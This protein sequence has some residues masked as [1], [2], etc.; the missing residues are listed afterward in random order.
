MLWV[1]SLLCPPMFWTLLI[2]DFLGEPVPLGFWVTL[3]LLPFVPN[4]LHPSRC[5]CT[6]KGRLHQAAFWDCYVPLSVSPFCSVSG[7]HSGAVKGLELDLPGFN[8]S[9]APA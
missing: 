7:D 3:F 5:L 8:P 9:P 6:V 1:T 2:L 4:L